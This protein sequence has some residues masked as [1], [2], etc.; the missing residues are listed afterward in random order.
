MNARFR[1][2]TVDDLPTIR[3]IEDA[4][5]SHPW[6]AGNFS[7]AL[8]AGYN[9]WMLIDADTCLGYSVSMRVLDEAHLLN[10][11]VAPAHRRQGLG[12]VLLAHAL[13]HAAGQ[14][15]STAFLEVRVSNLHAIALYHAHGFSDLAQRRDYYP[16]SPGRED[17]LI[18]KLELAC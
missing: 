13:E 9:A 11:T 8:A 15:A 3:P 14:G 5:Y 10:L 16:A 4:S 18:M 7:D 1:P 2:M 17:A 6:S 12:R